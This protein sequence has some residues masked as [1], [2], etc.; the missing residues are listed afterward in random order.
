MLFN[1]FEVAC[2]YV[3]RA[4]IDEFTINLVGE[5]VQIVFITG[6]SDFISEGYE[7]SALHYLMKPVSEEKLF[8]V[9][10][11]AAAKLQKTEKLIQIVYNSK[12][13]CKD[14]VCLKQMTKIPF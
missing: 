2:R 8:S 10:D 4:G 13:K 7:V 11:R 1:S 3:W 14:F 12:T 9:L 5:K 6:F